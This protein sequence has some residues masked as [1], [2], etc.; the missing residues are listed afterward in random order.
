ML[1]DRFIV[2]SFEFRIQ[3]SKRF[4][5]IPSPFYFGVYLRYN[6]FIGECI[7]WSFGF[8]KLVI[9]GFPKVSF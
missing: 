1:F 2:L 7:L 8:G 5:K 3:G 6:V 4:A 9:G